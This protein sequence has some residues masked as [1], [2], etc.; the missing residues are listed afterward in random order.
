MDTKDN[1]PAFYQPN[2]RRRTALR[3]VKSKPGHYGLPKFHFDADFFLEI[4]DDPHFC[5]ET[6]NEFVVY[7]EHTQL[8]D[9]CLA[10]CSFD[11]KDKYEIETIL[12]EKQSLYFECRDGVVSFNFEISGL[13]GPTRTLYIHSILREPGL[14]LRIEQNNIGRRAGKY[15]EGD[16]PAT[17]ILAANHYMFAMREIVH[18]LDL[19]QYLNRNQLGYLLILGFETNNE[20]HTDY[21][22]HWHLIYRW[23]TYAGSPAPHI[24]LALDGKMTKNVCYVDCHRGC[25]KDYAP[26]DWCPLIDPYGHDLCAVRIDEDGGMSV[27]KPA[28]SIYRM[29][30]YTPEGVTVYKD[31]Q[32]IGVIHTANDTEVGKFQVRWEC[33]ASSSARAS[34]TETISYDPLTGAIRKIENSSE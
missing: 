27:T 20:V 32:S 4:V 14:T 5:Y 24:Y 34:Y 31:G 18:A 19:P 15:R 9:A 2:H 8:V 13:T 21:P 7:V 25:C 26:G 3:L 11:T 17:E 10:T 29:G 30:P 1:I 6:D 33:P 28:A 12:C 22:P 23:P 16:Y